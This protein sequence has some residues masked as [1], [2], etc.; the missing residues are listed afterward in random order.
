PPLNSVGCHLINEIVAEEESDI[1]WDGR[2]LSHFEM[3][4]ESMQQCGANTNTILSFINSI[5]QKKP[6]NIVLSEHTVPR[7]AKD[8]I[9]STFKIIEM[10]VHQ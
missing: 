4:L 8:F 10:E 2:H 3:Y 7:I 9:C 6:L 5:K 1:T